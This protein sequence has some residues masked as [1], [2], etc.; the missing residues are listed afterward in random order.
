MRIA[1]G[2]RARSTAALATALIAAI[3]FGLF[4]ASPAQAAEFPSGPFVIELHKYEQPVV[5][6]DPATGL[7]LDPSALPSTD[8][9]PGA[10]FTATRV[11]GVDVSTNSGQQFAA[12]LTPAE[13]A[14]RIPAGTPPHATATTDAL[15]NATLDLGMASGLYLVSEAVVPDGYHG[16][17]DFL[18]VL[19]L[20]NPQTR[21]GWLS[22]VHVYPKN[23]SLEAGTVLQV[24]DEDVWAC[25][26]PVTWN[27]IATI[28]AGPTISGYIIQNLLDPGLEFF[29]ALSDVTVQVTGASVS[30]GADYLVRSATIDGREAF[31][32]VFTEAGRAKLVA[33]R[34]SNPDAVVT[35][36]Y[37]TIVRDNIPGEYTN[38]MRLLPTAAA[39]DGAGVANALFRGEAPAASAWFRAAPPISASLVSTATVK[40]GALL[41]IVEEN[42]NP[43]NRIAG[44]TIQLFR[45]EADATAR[46]NPIECDGNN[47]WV[48]DANGEVLIPCLRLSNFQNGMELA[49]N[50]PAVRDYWVAM[51]RIPAGWTGSDRPVPVQVTSTSIL[52]PAV[53]EL[54]LKRNGGSGD[55]PVTGAQITGLVM[56]GILLVGGGAM[57]LLR[58]RERDEDERA[59]ERTGA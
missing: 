12:S 37:E 8:P 16:S 53:V 33:A 27:P 34:V 19:P 54:V 52:H 38:E 17:A 20:T 26:D 3:T 45:S 24:T 42:G 32:V 15:G 31:E 9:V 18:V 13:A 21:D 28:P 1:F 14:T 48:S 58:R 36:G 4:T 46:V 7:P 44:A 43:G 6:G 10:T 22:T 41:V 50:D 23:L 30:V 2:S 40:F 29:G 35:V 56:L 59:G 49:P 25:H 11:P 57:V 55:L 47:L 5:P 39:I 51:T